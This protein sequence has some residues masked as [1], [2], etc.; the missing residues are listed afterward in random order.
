MHSFIGK[1]FGINTIIQRFALCIQ[2]EWAT[3][4]SLEWNLEDGIKAAAT[5]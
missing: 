4:E 3:R 2:L 1:Q 5:L